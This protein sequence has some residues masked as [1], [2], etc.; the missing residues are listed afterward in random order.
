MRRCVCTVAAVCASIAQ[1]QD[2]ASLRGRQG[3]S[4]VI[5]AA[6]ASGVTGTFADSR[7]LVTWDRVRAIDGESSDELAGFLDAGGLL[8]R[9]TSRLDRGDA[10]AAL[11]VLEQAYE[12]FGD[13][14]GATGAVAADALL[15]AHLALGNPDRCVLPWLQLLEHD[16]SQ[17]QPLGSHRAAIDSGTG[18]VPE[19]PPIF[20]PSRSAV[21]RATELAGDEFGRWTPGTNRRLAEAYASAFLIAAGERPPPLEGE[22]SS[23]GVR[24]VQAIV[25]ARSDDPNRRLT[26]RVALQGFLDAEHPAWIDAWCH[27]GIGLSLLLESESDRLAGVGHLLV[28]PSEHAETQPSLACVCLA[29]S[30]LTLA[31][32][33]RPD[34]AGT[35]IN[36]LERIAP[37]HPALSLPSLRGIRAISAPTS[38]N[39]TGP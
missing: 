30:A 4:V 33:G 39:G 1:A 21:R 23:E 5:E 11:S 19:L 24:L 16:V 12:V 7:L 22:A 27:A 31:D 10:V 17:V 13:Q 3:Q 34:A 20:L 29:Y 2:V 28:V 8:W 6:D 35:L 9:G 15:A 25:E 14:P 32:A 26:A 36:E 38:T 37:R 18:L